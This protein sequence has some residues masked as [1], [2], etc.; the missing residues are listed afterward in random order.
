[1]IDIQEGIVPEIVCTST[2]KQTVLNLTFMHDG[3][4]IEKAQDTLQVKPDKNQ[5]VDFVMGLN[6]DLP[7]GYALS[8]NQSK[9]FTDAYSKE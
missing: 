5:L 7:E 3:S 4:E 1:M 6:V 8:Q 2:N 9:A